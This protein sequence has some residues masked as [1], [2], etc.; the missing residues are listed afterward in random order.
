[1]SDKPNQAEGNPYAPSGTTPDKAEP[2]KPS[3]RGYALRYATLGLLVGLS[4]GSAFSYYIFRTAGVRDLGAVV[5][6]CVTALVFFASLF[7]L[8]GF[9]LGAMVDLIRLV[10][11]RP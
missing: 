1:M 7:V 5:N 3:Y 10:M 8:I 6:D 4:L 9:L 2:T 11:R